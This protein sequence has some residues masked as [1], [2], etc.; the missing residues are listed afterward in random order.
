[1]ERAIGLDP[2][3]PQ[4]LQSLSRNY[5]YLRR[6]R[7]VESLC[8]RLIELSPDKP[9]F[10]LQTAAAA[11]LLKADLV[12]FRTTLEHLRASMEES[13]DLAYVRLFAAVQ[14]CDWC[15]AREILNNSRNDDFPFLFYCV[16]V[17][18]VCIELWISRLEKGHPPTERRFAAARDQLKRRVDERPEDARLLSALRLVDAALGR[19]QEAIEGA[20]HA[21][22]MLPVSQD[23]WDGPGLVLYQTRVYALTG[24][25]DLALK[26]L[27]LSVKTP[28]GEYY[29]DLKLDPSLNPLRKDP[30]F[31]KFLA[32]LAPAENISVSDSEL[33][34]SR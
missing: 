27:A 32:H 17:P 26:N 21:V 30:R 34:R 13:I 20:G 4:L 5:L 22:E 25:T 15:R 9:I 8:H 16:V 11:F 7:E 12:S 3:N 33:T 1:M 18:K 24:E 29:C 23:A 10:K 31:E 28:G 2:R 14:A 19:K 6:Y